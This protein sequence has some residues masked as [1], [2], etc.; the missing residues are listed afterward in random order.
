MSK[1]KN[2]Y[3]H[4]NNVNNAE[5]NVSTKMH[6]NKS[7][8][9]YTIIIFLSLFFIGLIITSSIGAI[10]YGAKYYKPYLEKYIS[11]KIN[12]NVTISKVETSWNNWQP[13]II[14][15][16]IIVKDKKNSQKIWFSSE[17][18]DLKLNKQH[19]IKLSPSFYKVTITN[20]YILT[21]ENDKGQ[22]LLFNQNNTNK[23]NDSLPSFLF[24]HDYINLNNLNL[25]AI[26]KNKV[27][28]NSYIN[29]NLHKNNSN[30]T[31]NYFFNLN[32]NLA[33]I[34]IN[35]NSI[36]TPNYQNDNFL[37][38]FKEWKGKSST[39]IATK[40][41]N[42][43]IHVYKAFLNGI[44]KKNKHVTNLINK[45]DLIQAAHGEINLNLNWNKV[46]VE[47]AKI[48]VNFTNFNDRSINSDI[49]LSSYQN[50][51][52]KDKDL[53]KRALSEP[54]QKYL[55]DKQMLINEQYIWQVKDLSW[56]DKL[57]QQHSIKD[58]VASHPYYNY[59]PFNISIKNSDIK[60]YLEL[61]KNFTKDKSQQ[62]KLQTLQ[63]IKL[64]AYIQNLKLSYIPY[65][66]L[67][68]LAKYHL[69]TEIK[70][71]QF[72]YPLNFKN[73]EI[74]NNFLDIIG[75]N[76]FNLSFKGNLQQGLANIN[77]NNIS[78]N[79]SNIKSQINK[80]DI[81]KFNTKLKWSINKSG[82][83]L[84]INDIY[85]QNPN[86][87]IKA[88]AK[89]IIPNSNKNNNKQDKLFN[90]QAIANAT[91][92]SYLRKLF[93]QQ[94]KHKSLNIIDSLKIDAP[95]K[96]AKLN[97]IFPISE[98]NFTNPNTKVE[99]NLPINNASFSIPQH[100]DKIWPRFNNINGNFNFQKD[101]INIKINNALIDIKTADNSKLT[102]D[103]SNVII[104]NLITKPILKLELKSS[105]SLMSMMN[106]IN[107]SP[108]H[109][110][111]GNIN[112]KTT[113]NAG[114]KLNLNLPFRDTQQIKVN[115]S[116]NLINNDIEF[117]KGLPLF[118]QINGILNFNEK[119]FNFN[120]VKA[121]FLD[122]EIYADGYSKEHQV[123]IKANG[124]I[125]K[126]KL[127]NYAATY[128]FEKIIPHINGATKYNA[129]LSIINKQ[130]KLDV[131]SDLQ[132][133]DIIMPQPIGKTS[134]QSIP[135]KFTWHLYNP[136]NH[137]ERI[138]LQYNDNIGAI[139]EQN[140]IEG[141]AKNI[142]A[143]YYAHSRKSN[144][145]LPDE[146]VQAEI[147]LDKINLDE[148]QKFHTKFNKQA[149]SSKDTQNSTSQYIPQR[150]AAYT[151]S[152]KAMDREIKN[153][154]FGISKISDKT[155]A[156]NISSSHINGYIKIKQTNDGQEIDGHFSQISIPN[157][158]QT[159]AIKEIIQE[160]IHELPNVNL[161]INS[162]NF[163]NKDL[164]NVEIIADNQYKN[165]HR[166]WDIKK[167]LLENPQATFNASGEWNFYNGDN[168]TADTSQT[169]LKINLNL[170]NVGN[171]LNRLGLVQVIKNGNGL[172]DAELS[173]QGS[174]LEFNYQTLNGNSNMNIKDGVILKVDPAAAKLLGIFSLQGLGNILT[175]NWNK[176]FSQGSPFDEINNIN[177]I[178]NG[179]INIDKFTLKSPQ[180]K[181]EASGNVSLI[182][183]TQNIN[184]D[185]YPKINAGSA[186]LAYSLINPAIGLGTLIAQVA[187]Q[188]PL[189]KILRQ[190]YTLKG[191]WADPIVKKQ[192]F[193]S[194]LDR[195]ER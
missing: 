34:N 159:T 48:K 82:T 167:I 29:L 95:I 113:G 49:L 101:K 80:L 165:K 47:T 24:K 111:I 54:Q 78:V 151:K 41:N 153:I 148:W 110:W 103:N 177:T 126:D 12:L 112:Y 135:L 87:N 160:K 142:R 129:N 119:G 26:N 91:N 154:I 2:K 81:D 85:I 84:D 127:N 5:K 79:L 97:F 170:H 40:L 9:K 51:S 138:N 21:E 169:K 141:I 6:D 46:N 43:N 72:I 140:R 146:G 105:S 94:S 190:S 158:E 115:G 128:G 117:V 56:T 143:I 192:T 176:L 172:M 121:R 60:P 92:F 133:L 62:K 114:L 42:E 130:I 11:N 32:A 16:N 70:N 118:N 33:G 120:Q 93:P 90:I 193:N 162:F 88:N 137:S 44:I 23:N 67:A 96:N 4:E 163:L 25:H 61:V 68:E 180:A 3:T 74:K 149:V 73:S 57:K 58:I 75:K 65:A 171:L 152:L 98:P 194:H 175:F 10:F 183:E 156:G 186:S 174:P 157:K 55:S 145:A 89:Y 83:N 35:L 122:E 136:E 59:L 45:I 31:K 13:N 178:N 191:K 8:K 38:Y 134:E 188:N 15:K 184:A 108:V 17:L 28:I 164:G 69:E 116:L 63:N 106:Y 19:E 125:N 86:F 107:T 166:Y 189:G 76:G 53:L 185:V 37:G 144:I 195:Q 161:K 187:L 100:Q 131:D 155:W 64:K 36:F 173:W 77:A 39:N 182:N 22:W 150:V 1:D 123:Q 132:G 71:I 147:N 50:T 20:S 14:L 124:L 18:I 102:I 104:D 30:N 66:G 27:S 181:V 179:L 52:L 99:I 139:I 109:N 7:W 168:N